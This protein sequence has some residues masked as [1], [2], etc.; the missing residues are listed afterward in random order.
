[1]IVFTQYTDTMD[2]LRD[3]L[4]H[5]Y[6]AQV[7]C[8]S[9]RGGERWDGK[10]WV[11]TS[12]E[13]I[14]TAFRERQDIKILLCTESASEGLNL[15]TCGV[16]INFDLPWNPM[17]VEQRIGRIDRIGQVYPGRVGS[18][19]LLRRHGGGDDLPAA[20]RPHY[21]VRERGG[22]AAADPEPGGPGDRGGGDGERRAAR[23]HRSQEHV[24]EINRLVTRRRQPES[25]STASSATPSR[26]PPR[27]LCL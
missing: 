17:R 15:Q 6:G 27:C 2:Y 24:E 21:V 4:R 1:M 26:C 22:R 10:A 12:K 20:G 25:I 5:V 3:K 11:G 9:G 14:K 7:A 23:G 13:N 16:L 19:L 18:Q 8:Y